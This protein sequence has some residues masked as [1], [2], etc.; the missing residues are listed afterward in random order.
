MSLKAAAA[1][2]AIPSLLQA[3][4]ILVLSSIDPCNDNPGCMA[5]NV[6]TYAAILILP[7]TLIILIV[8]TAIAFARRKMSGR[9]ALI[10]NSL[11]A[12]AP[13]VLVFAPFVYN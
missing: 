7:A 5:G 1:A 4:C 2:V 11:F 9:R 8:S 10:T 3:F 6:T 13:F 12:L